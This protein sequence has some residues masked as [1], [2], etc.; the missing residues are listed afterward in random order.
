MKLFIKLF[1]KVRAT[2][3]DC[4]EVADGLF[5]A[6]VARPVSMQIEQVLLSLELHEVDMFPDGFP[7]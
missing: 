1:G 7:T 5:C 2:M 6:M 3:F 4:P